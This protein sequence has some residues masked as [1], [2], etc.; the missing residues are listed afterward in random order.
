MVPEALPMSLHLSDGARV[1]IIGGG[2]AGSFAA[3]HLLHLAR[4]RGWKNL[5]V[6]IFEP[7]YFER[8]GPGGCNRCAGILSYRL[9]SGMETLE[10]ILPEETVQA[11][12]HAYSIHLHGSK[13]RIAQPDPTRRIVTVYRGGGPC[14]TRDPVSAISFDGFLLTQT[15]ERGA[16]HV[17]ERAG[18]VTMG[19]DKLTIHPTPGRSTPIFWC[20][21]PA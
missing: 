18:K 16:V 1:C 7:R 6:L 4:R 21:P 14:M 13:L 10:L 20:W 15:C 17:Q 5:E 12:L 9:L 2:P 3:L 8:S 19:D 11:E